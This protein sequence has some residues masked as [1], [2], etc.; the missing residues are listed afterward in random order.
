MIHVLYIHAVIFA[1]DGHH[2]APIFDFILYR[3]LITFLET[4]PVG[5]KKPGDDN[6]KFSVAIFIKYVALHWNSLL[7]GVTNDI[8]CR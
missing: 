8:F 2:I 7:N 4:T 3:D 6:V 1:D 5:S